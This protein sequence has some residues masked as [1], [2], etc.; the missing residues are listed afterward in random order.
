MTLALAWINII[1]FVCTLVSI[2]ILGPHKHYN[3][4]NKLQYIK[5]QY[6]KTWGCKKAVKSVASIPKTKFISS[7]RM[8][9]WW[10]IYFYSFFDTMFYTIQ[11]NNILEEC[12]CESPNLRLIW[13]GGMIITAVQSTLGRNCI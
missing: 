7:K 4:W 3:N 6:T 13:F 1:L 10:N 9:C 8:V 12:F 11:L 2:I 5:T